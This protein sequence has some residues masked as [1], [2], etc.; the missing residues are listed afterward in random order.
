MWIYQ[1][2]EFKD[3]HIPEGA[4]G[5]V[6]VMH[7]TIDGEVKVYIGKKNFYSKNRVAKGK[8]ELALM[9]DKRGSKKKLVVKPSYHNYF[10]SNDVLQE[11]HKNG[12][13]IKRRIIHICYSKRELTYQE[14]KW[15]FKLDVL[16][17][18]RYLNNSI[19]SK[20]YRVHL[21]SNNPKINNNVKSKETI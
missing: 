6:Y 21:E 11:A 12:V 3:E 1:G 16:E 5:F 17:D 7:A 20:F 10:S 13:E 2:K 8:K 4:E 15:M 19:L 9:E 14:A 18:P